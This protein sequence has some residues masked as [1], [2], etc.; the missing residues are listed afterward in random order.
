[1]KAPCIAAVAGMFG[2]LVV[3]FS[4]FQAH[5]ELP[6]AYAITDLGTLGGNS[7]GASGINNLGQVVG[8][9]GTGDLDPRGK[10]SG[11][12]FL[13]LPEPAYGLPAGMN[14]LGSPSDWGSSADD[15]TDDGI[16][17]G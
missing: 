15:I 9:A 16:V 13:W 12:A 10:M 7:S 5:A 3:S 17:A 4:G 11:H 1:M 2:L 6:P 8:W 14:D